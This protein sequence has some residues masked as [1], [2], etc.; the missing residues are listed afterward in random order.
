MSSFPGQGRTLGSST[1]T[2]ERPSSA[3]QQTASSTNQQA[4]SGGSKDSANAERYVN[5]L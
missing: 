4:Q 2:E 5:P 3:E 1:M